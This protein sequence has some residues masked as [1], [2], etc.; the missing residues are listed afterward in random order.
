MDRTLFLVVS[1]VLLGGCYDVSYP[2]TYACSG[3]YT[4]CP[5]GYT[6]DEANEVC[7]KEGSLVDQGQDMPADAGSDAA[8]DAGSDLAREAGPDLATDAKPDVLDQGTDAKPD[9]LDQGADA[10]PDV[11]DQG[12]DAQP[13][14]GPDLA[15]DA[16]AD[17]AADLW[18]DTSSPDAGTDTTVVDAG[19]PVNKWVTVKAGAFKMGAPGA[20]TCFQPNASLGHKESQ[21]AVTLTRAFEISSFPVTQ[22]QLKTLRGYSPSGFTGCPQCPVESITWSEAA[23]YCNALSKKNGLTQCYICTTAFGPQDV[24]C[25]TVSA[26]TGQQIYGCPGYRLATEAEYE[27]AHRAGTT[28]PLTNGTLTSCAK[29]PVAAANGWYKYNAKSQSRVVGQ[30]PANALGLYDMAGNVFSWCQDTWSDDLGSKAK[31]DPVG[32]AATDMRAVRG[33]SWDSPASHLRAAYRAPVKQTG[34][35][36]TVG[37]RCVRTLKP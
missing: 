7:V 18:P 34:R 14:L 11:L 30:K 28:T 17:A 25:S 2:A 29:D 32:T 6:C 5:T 10:K 36:K 23:A 15:F 16:A 22:A 33:A 20:E 19:G 12:A 35:D 1:A 3:E 4:R 37:V 31:T 8:S 24:T 27:R 9:V 26:Y 21:H 13:D